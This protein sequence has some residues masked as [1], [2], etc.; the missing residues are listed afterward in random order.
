MNPQHI[1]VRQPKNL[2]NEFKPRPQINHDVLRNLRP[3]AGRCVIELDAPDAMAGGLHVPD[4]AQV[5]KVADIAFW[6][7]VLAMTPRRNP[8]TGEL[9]S[10]LFGAGD[11][12]WVMGRTE[13]LDKTLIVTDNTRVYAMEGK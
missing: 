8:K 9:T 12:V 1:P 6:G 10:E 7:T 11:R 5:R 4:V 3:C 2:P 13:D